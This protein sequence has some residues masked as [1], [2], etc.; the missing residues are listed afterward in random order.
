MAKPVDRTILTGQES[1]IMFRAAIKNPWTRD[2]Y[3][4]RLINFLTSSEVRMTPDEF[5]SLAKNPQTA[6]EAEKKI[7]SFIL[8]ENDRKENGKITASTVGNALKAVRTLLEMNDVT[9]FNWKKMKRILPKA[10]KYALDRNPTAEEIRDIL[11]VAD[12]RGKPLTL[13]FISGGIR[14]G[15]V[16]GL[17]VRDYTRT[18]RQGQS[19]S[20]KNQG[21]TT[22]TLGRL[23]VYNGEPERYVT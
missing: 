3:E 15:A 21:A 13:L 17:K 14:E 5:V 23:V 2:P 20:Y 9:H 22:V 6:S 10:R 16:E 12:L 18:D 7:V 1:M 8:K 4:R 19:I 11:Q